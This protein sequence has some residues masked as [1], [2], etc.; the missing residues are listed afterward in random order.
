METPKLKVNFNLGSARSPFFGEAI[1]MET[2]F[3]YDY[4]LATFEV[5]SIL[6]RSDLNGNFFVILLYREIVF[7]SPFFGE[8][9]WMETFFL[10]NKS[11]QTPLGRLHSL[12]KRFEWKHYDP[13]GAGDGHFLVCLHSLEKRFEWKHDS[14]GAIFNIPYK[15]LHSLEKRFEWKPYCS[16]KKKLV[17]SRLSPFFGEAIWME[18]VLHIL[19]FSLQTKYESPFFGEAIW[20]ETIGIPIDSASSVI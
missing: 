12:E 8:A 5:V 1:W 9:I 16:H 7:S 14:Q 19:Y 20:M 15:G 11:V 18:T 13:V 2:K 10:E 4:N 6:W 3:N 17:W